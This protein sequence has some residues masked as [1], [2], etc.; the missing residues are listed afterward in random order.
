MVLLAGFYFRVSGLYRGLTDDSPYIFH[1]DAPKQVRALEG[2]LRGRYFTYVGSRMYDG[3]PFGLNHLDEW[4]IRPA[5]LMY[6]SAVT[7]T[8]PDVEVAKRP[9]TEQ[10]YV[11]VR[12]LRVAYGVIVILLTYLLC[13][14]V[15][16]HGLSIVAA[17][18]VAL[19]PLSITVCKSGSGDIGL[20]LFG[21][22]ALL[23]LAVFSTRGSRTLLCLAGLGV[24][25]AFGAKYQGLL[26]GFAVAAWVLIQ[27]FLKHRSWRSFIGDGICAGLGCV[28]GI[29]LTIPQFVTMPSETWQYIVHGIEYIKNY[30]T[31]EE[32]RALPAY[33]RIGEC[34]RANT[35]P[36]L[37]SIG[38]PVIALSLAG[39]VMA[40]KRAFA[41]STQDG[42]PLACLLFAFL[43]LFLSLAG[44]RHVQP[45]HFSYLVPVLAVG[46]VYAVHEFWKSGRPGPQLLASVLLVAAC[47]ELGLKTKSE[48]YFW[49]REDLYGTAMSFAGYQVLDSRIHHN[50]RRRAYESN[51]LIKTLALEGR[52]PAVFRN[53]PRYMAMEDGHLWRKTHIAPLPSIPFHHTHHWIFMNGPVF[54]I[55]DRMARLRPGEEHEQGIVFYSNPQTVQVGLRSGS[56]PSSVRV[57][58]GGDRKT[59]ELASHS[60]E[61]I[62]LKPVKWRHQ[63]VVIPEIEEIFIV[64]LSVSCE[65]GAVWMTVLD[66]PR[67]VWNHTLFGGVQPDRPRPHMGEMDRDLFSGNSEQIRYLRSRRG[68][69]VHPS[70]D[71]PGWIDLLPQYTALAAGAY[72]LTLDM[73]DVESNSTFGIVVA[74]LR[75]GGQLAETSQQFELLDAQERIDYRFSKP[76]APYECTVLV[77]CEAGGGVITGWN[78]EPDG[79]RIL[80]GVT[81]AYTDGTKPDWLRPEPESW[82]H[83]PSTQ[84]CG[85]VFDEAVEIV[86]LDFPESAMAGDTVELASRIRLHRYTDMDFR[87]LAI[88]CHIIDEKDAVLTAFGC[89]LRR[90]AIGTAGQA[91]VPVT[92][93]GDLTPGRHRL[94]VGIWNTRTRHRVPLTGR[95]EALQHDVD[96]VILGT[97]EI[98]PPA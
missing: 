17:L 35:G 34:L 1:P 12:S 75:S 3:Y 93:P 50:P 89:E 43:S 28:A 47:A 94:R 11:W 97:I 83:P 9:S 32:F 45:F 25:C 64:P 82:V 16:S 33:A 58:L 86:S 53:R 77:S 49:S 38:W 26:F 42:L 67:E 19:S 76:F 91:A 60:Q 48:N 87:S 51:W 84:L 96:S 39:V 40:A 20:D 41:G 37:L 36:I 98:H 2:F 44:K 79:D 68:L 85:V 90:C 72:R 70:S 4:I 73:T 71:G 69:R 59:V 29:V 81:R 57:E 46:A 13:R 62:L 61:I 24:G 65:P 52:N 18:I 14:R 95:P 27:C 10:L 31:S 7:I 15:V 6:R 54:P 74:G 63:Q 5:W 92:L 55:N 22:G 88:F 80:E 21:T 8:S 23:M 66:D 56:E 30:N 78:L